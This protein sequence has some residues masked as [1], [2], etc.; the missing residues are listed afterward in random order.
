MQ[1]EGTDSSTLPGKNL[2]MLQSS[3]KV[4]GKLKKKSISYNKIQECIAAGIINPIKIHTGYN[5]ADFLE[6]HWPGKSHTIVQDNSTQGG[7]WGQRKTCRVSS[8]NKCD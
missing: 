6:K 8:S 1:T 4:D 2:G 5:L 7:S 3:T